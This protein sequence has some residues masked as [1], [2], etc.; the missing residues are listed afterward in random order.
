MIK[1]EDAVRELEKEWTGLR[2]AVESVP[3]N[4]LEVPGVVEEWSVKDIL[5]HVAFWA[6][7]GAKT[8]AAS[9]A[10][11]MSTLVFGEGDG[12]VDQWNARELAA[13]KNKPYNDIRGE[14]VTAHESAR[15]ALSAATDDTLN[16]PFRQATVAEYY[17]GDTYEHYK[18]HL[19][20][21]KS[22]LRE[23]ATT[24]K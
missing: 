21:I 17:A 20:H 8:L 4:E 15:Q 6:D 11:D 24:E 3:E 19:E 7:R 18:E 12:W 5:G 16:A 23:Q 9:N 2:S 1:K 14:W 13:R 22:W 10:G